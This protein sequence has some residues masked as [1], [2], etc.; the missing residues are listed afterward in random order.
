MTETKRTV[1][2]DARGEICPYPMMKATEA[3]EHA[4]EGDVIEVLTDHPPA[5]ITIPNAAVKLGWD[6]AIQRVASAE[7]KLVLTKSRA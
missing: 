2:L 6:V 5:L 7:W 4:Q 1:K 3:I